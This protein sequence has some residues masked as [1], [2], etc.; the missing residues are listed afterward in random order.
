HA[1][2][3]GVEL[4][5]F[6]EGEARPPGAA[7]ANGHA[8]AVS[9]PIIVGDRVTG[10]LTARDA[11]GDLAVAASLVLR[12]AASSA[13]RLLDLARHA[14]ELPIRSRSELIAELLMSDAPLSEDLRDRAMHLAVPIGGWPVAGRTEADDP[15]E[16]GRDEVHRFELLETAGQ[17]ALQATA[18]TGGSWYLSR[19]ARAIVL[20]RMTSSHPGAQAGMRAARSAESSLAA[21][22]GRLPGLRL[23]G[24]V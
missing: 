6:A 4:R 17:A 3:T 13:G 18:R 10:E 1:L 11:H 12:A 19:V 5:L 24:G 15:D 14:R 9:V 23:R 20:V 16:A 8:G 2:G 7:S 22:R 21:V